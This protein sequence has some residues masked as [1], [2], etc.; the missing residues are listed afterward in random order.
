MNVQIDKAGRQYAVGK[1]HQA[2]IFGNFPARPR[3]HF[4]DGPVVHQKQRLLNP[5]Q[6]CE[7]R[8]GGD[9]DHAISMLYSKATFYRKIRHG[10][11][12][13]GL[14]CEAGEVPA[15]DDRQFNKA[16][17]QASGKCYTF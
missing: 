4:H 8:A 16:V 14:R 15:V 11:E 6:R 2:A 5:L 7:Q 9:R 3:G 13:V 12:I 1:I 10:L 17:S